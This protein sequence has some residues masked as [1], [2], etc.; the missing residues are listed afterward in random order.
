MRFSYNLSSVSE[1]L[2]FNPD[3]PCVFTVRQVIISY[4]L[5][6][7]EEVLCGQ[8]LLCTSTDSLTLPGIKLVKEKMYFSNSN[9]EIWVRIKK[10][11]VLV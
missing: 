11:A 6:F 4:C 5:H 1:E 8:Y 2:G 10:S 9:E 7:L 3:T